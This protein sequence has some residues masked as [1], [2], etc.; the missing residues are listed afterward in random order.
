MQD[1]WRYT[2]YHGKI[3]IRDVSHIIIIA[4]FINSIIKNFHKE[5]MNRFIKITPDDLT[6]SKRLN[7]DILWSLD[8]SILTNR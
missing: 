1:H 8:E 6:M 7:S 5:V 4:P 2:L 3:R